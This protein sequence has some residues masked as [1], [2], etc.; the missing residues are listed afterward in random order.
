MEVAG[1]AF[2]G[3]DMH[4]ELETLVHTHEHLVER[5][6]APEKFK[7]LDE[8]QCPRCSYRLEQDAPGNSGNTSM[9][10][11]AALTGDVE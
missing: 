4:L 11:F 6:A 8:L 5:E 7:L 3:V 9:R 10:G 2:I 1:V